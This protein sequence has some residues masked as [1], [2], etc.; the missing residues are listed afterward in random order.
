MANGFTF[1]MTWFTIVNDQNGFVTIRK[2]RTPAEEMNT[3]FNYLRDQT[4]NTLE[5]KRAE[6]LAQAYKLELNIQGLKVLREED[7]GFLKVPDT[8]N[9]N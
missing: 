5:H 9:L 3:S 1:T 8:R 4:I 7:V 6:L 2:A